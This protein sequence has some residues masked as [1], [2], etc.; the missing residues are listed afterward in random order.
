MPWAANKKKEPNRNQ[1]MTRESK[2]TT[3]NCKS[4]SEIE[5]W[6]TIKWTASLIMPKRIWTFWYEIKLHWLYNYIDVQD[7]NIVLRFEYWLWLFKGVFTL[8]EYC[9][10][11]GVSPKLKTKVVWRLVKNERAAAF[12]EYNAQQLNFRLRGS[13]PYSRG[14]EFFNWRTC[15][16]LCW[17]SDYRWIWDLIFRHAWVHG[18]NRLWWCWHDMIFF[19]SRSHDE[20]LAPAVGGLMVPEGWQDLLARGQ[21]QP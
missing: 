6:V 17:K 21:A 3:H 13:I 7:L 12:L 9:V 8:C 19:L 11:F 5:W 4:C 14:L 18:W 2:E 1:E 20:R 10:D 16:E 15:F